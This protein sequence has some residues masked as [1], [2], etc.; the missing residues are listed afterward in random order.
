MRGLSPTAAYVSM[1]KCVTLV[2][3][4]AQQRQAVI[5]EA[6]T[7]E[8]VPFKW[9]TRIKGEHGGCDCGQLLK[10]SFAVVG[11]DA[12]LPEYSTQFFLHSGDELYLREVEKYC[13]RV[14]S[15]Q[16]GD[17]VLF[18]MGRAYGHA[19]IVI[20]WPQII[21]AHGTS[22]FV[23]KSDAVTDPDFGWRE[24]RFYSP[25]QWH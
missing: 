19:G 1:E 3:T 9:R 14:K 6:L 12:T 5:A 22:Q 21:H 18:K 13:I 10:A 20:R 16:P 8:W 24:K 4:P 25:K 2:T 7:W 23:H 17:I 11:I 15:P